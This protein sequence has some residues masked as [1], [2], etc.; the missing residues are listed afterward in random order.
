MQSPFNE[1]AKQL[2]ENGYSPIPIRPG[3][4]Y[5]GLY[6][7]TRWYPLKAW[8]Q[9]SITQPTAEQL[10]NWAT[11]PGAGIGIAL[12]P[13]SSNVVAIDLDY[14]TP[15]MVAAIEACLPGS[16]VM[17]VGAKG[18]TA[19]YKTD[20]TVR[21]Q[22]FFAPVKKG[23]HPKSVCEVLGMGNQTVIPPTI[24]PDTQNPYE[25]KEMGV[26]LC[27]VPA[28]ELPELTNEHVEAISEAL[29]PFNVKRKGVRPDKSE[30]NGDVSQSD[31][32][33]YDIAN[34]LSLADLQSW[35]EEL[36][37]YNLEQVAGGY[38]A[39]A[40]WRSSSSGRPLAERSQNLSIN[41]N[42]IKD[43]GIDQGYSPVQLVMAARGIDSNEALWWLMSIVDPLTNWDDTEHVKSIIASE[44]K[45][46]ALAK[47]EQLAAT[48]PT[49]EE[50]ADVKAEEENTDNEVVKGLV[51]EFDFHKRLNSF[52]GVWSDLTDYL[53]S[54]APSRS[55]LMSG[56]TALT[57]CGALLGRAWAIEGRYT[58]YSNVYTLTVA[59]AAYGKTSR[60]SSVEKVLKLSDVYYRDLVPGGELYDD[61][62]DCF[63][64]V[65][66]S[67]LMQ[68][69]D[70]TSGAALY[71]MIKELPAVMASIDEFGGFMKK[72]IGKNIVATQDE[73]RTS[74]LKLYSASGSSFARSRRA[75]GSG[76]AK[77]KG[78]FDPVQN[79]SFNMIGATTPSD[80]REN[81]NDSLWSM[82]FLPRMMMHFETKEAKMQ[83]SKAIAPTKA[84]SGIA[85][86]LAYRVNKFQSSNG[87]IDG[88]K[89]ATPMIIAL[90][91]E[92]GEFVFKQLE[93]FTE[94]VNKLEKQGNPLA[95]AFNRAV[96]NALKVALILAVTEDCRAV[97]IQQKHLRFAFDFVSH[98]LGN[99]MRYFANMESIASSS[100]EANLKRTR[101]IITILRN[102]GGSASRTF[103]SL[104]MNKRG[105]DRQL[106][107]RL[108][109]GLM[110]SGT[111][112]ESVEQGKGRPKRNYSLV[113][114]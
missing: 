109:G 102:Q 3:T 103:V 81:Y 62:N 43:F 18:Y 80:F 88:S 76:S 87:L 36:D 55:P 64:R 45:K 25:W 82:G 63:T 9:F 21:A 22:K 97:T 17:K 31:G 47:A 10:A 107:D 42:G 32:D 78:R 79:P 57:Y 74:L 11:W 60:L 96:E 37:L 2:V 29:K 68:E 84:A 39:V 23:E 35:V 75:R 108:L 1:I 34:N 33:W 100:D 27:T 16:D 106:L 101:S 58:T 61:E 111:I 53:E 28:D 93:K 15:E 13:G 86:I 110:D 51:R 112:V 5:P 92:Q 91:E 83:A 72:F 41:R 77:I 90:S 99:Q 14:G 40:T 114:L 4:K 71:D 50:I 66:P 49:S 105:V 8:S 48:Q 6:D 20:G 56:L 98:L 104:K 46:S 7:G 26:D 54:A 89:T 44:D 95:D 70:V 69:G 73:I 38:K 30:D 59:G 65:Q 85:D 12:G 24:H 113:T 94:I 67:T 52:G 19:F